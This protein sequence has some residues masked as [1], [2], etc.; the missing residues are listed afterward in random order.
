MYGGSGADKFY[1]LKTDTGNKSAI[2]AD[3]IYDFDSSDTIYLHGSYSYAGNTS[4][5]KDG[6]CGIWKSGSDWVVTYNTTDTDGY[7]DIV[8]KGAD[9]HGHV[10]FFI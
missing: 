3:T 4:H 1:F 8:V 7:H 6:Q 9:P 2:R 10:S 5:P